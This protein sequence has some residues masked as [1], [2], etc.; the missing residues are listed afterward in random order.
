M[1]LRS[2]WGMLFAA[3][4]LLAGCVAGPDYRRPPAA[5]PVAFKED[6]NWKL[7]KPLDPAIAERWWTVFGDP[8]L[9]ALHEWL[10]L[11]NENLRALEAQYRQARAALDAAGAGRYPTAGAAGSV[12]RSYPG[13]PGS[14][15]LGATSLSA[16]A[17]ASWEPDLWG[18]VRRTVE[19]AEARLA[20]SDADLAAARLSVHALLT[21]TYFQL[22]AAEKQRALLETA[23]AAYTRSLELTRNRYRA[24]IISAGDV[25]QAESQ[26][27]ST[28]AQAIDARL[29]RAQLEHAIAVLLG[30]APSALTLPVADALPAV[31][32]VPQLI[33][34]TLLERR[35]DIAAA[36]RRV[37][38][39][40]AQ[41]GVAAAAF[42]PNLTLSATAG[43]RGSVLGDLFALPSRF[44][45]LGPSLAASLFDAG[46]RRA[47]SDQAI[48]AH[49]QAVANYRQT[50]LTAFQEVEDNLAAATLLEAEA[51]VQAEALA[52]SRR[53]LE[54]TNNQ[55]QAG[56]VSYIN[57]L[58]AQT[59]ALGAERAT[60]DVWNRRL[61][62]ANQLLKNAGG[63]WSAPA[64]GGSRPRQ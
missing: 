7:A 33:P 29:Q 9:D 5:V 4:G 34:S 28:E 1:T 35:P 58:T 64:A 55:Y 38:A 42:Y 24:G 12:T 18:R 47:A 8:A 37:A 56:I 60:L 32:P 6:P 17:S 57:V 19:G 48:A 30:T 22:R 14:G 36:E 39:A 62:A 43:Q 26:L 23:A 59:T 16:S 21:Q 10:E 46:A 54:I 20:A 45:A 49:D 31:P 11:S 27:K 40:N 50:V 51:K 41:I 13:T 15:S 25:V 2:R 61:L 63:Q 44:W 53:A 3:A 52:A